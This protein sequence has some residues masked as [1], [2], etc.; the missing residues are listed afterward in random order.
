VSI[1]ANLDFSLFQRG[2]ETTPRKDIRLY[3]ETHKDTNHL[4]ANIGELS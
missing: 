4:V 1:P 2:A 3:E